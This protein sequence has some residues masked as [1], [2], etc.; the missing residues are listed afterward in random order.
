MSTYRSPS[1]TRHAQEQNHMAETKEEEVSNGCWLQKLKPWITDFPL[2]WVPSY[3][4]PRHP[5]IPSSHDLSPLPPQHMPCSTLHRL[6]GWLL[7][8]CVEVGVVP[9]V[10]F[11][12]ERLGLSR[13]QVHSHTSKWSW[14]EGLQIP[15]MFQHWFPSPNFPPYTF[16]QKTEG[17]YISPLFLPPPHG[18]PMLILCLDF[19]DPCR[20]RAKAVLLPPHDWA[21]YLQVTK[22]K[23][24]VTRINGVRREPL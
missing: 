2:K 22:S 4:S 19:S 1:R 7:G 5:P 16:G 18:W 13:S 3:L 8:S 12:V 11:C 17:I 14:D 23:V 9:A 10:S 21:G 24:Y 6:A 15:K 20:A